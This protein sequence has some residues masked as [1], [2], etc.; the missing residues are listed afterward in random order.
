MTIILRDLV[1]RAESWP[2]GAQQELAQLALEIEGELK[3]GSYHATPG[4]LDGIDRGLRDAAEG[5]FASE[6]QVEAVFAK[7]R[8][9]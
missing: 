1:Q 4:E 3:S 8:R 6:D 5:K 7:H 9:K 2:E